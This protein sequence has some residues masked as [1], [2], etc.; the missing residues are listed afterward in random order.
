MISLWSSGSCN[1]G[2]SGVRSLVLGGQKLSVGS[3][4]LHPVSGLY[5]VPHE[6]ALI[7]SLSDGSIHVVYNISS[8]P[9]LIPNDDIFTSENLSKTARLAFIRIEPGEIK[10]SDVNRINGLLPYGYATVLWAHE[11]ARYLLLLINDVD[12]FFLLQVVPAYQFRVQL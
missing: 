3:S 1:L 10:S 6:D 7:T 9:T 11:Y 12:L 2:W 4:P 5:Y 8:E